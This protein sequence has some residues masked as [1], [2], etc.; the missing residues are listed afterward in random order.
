MRRRIALVKDPHRRRNPVS[1]R[2]IEVIDDRQ[3]GE[4]ILDEALKMIKSQEGS[5]L[6]INSWIDLL[7]GESCYAIPW[8]S[9]RITFRYSRPTGRFRNPLTPF[10]L[11]SVS[12]H[13]FIFLFLSAPSCRRSFPFTFTPL[14][15]LLQSSFAVILMSCFLSRGD[16]E[17]HENRIP[18]QT[19]P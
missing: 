13:I 15:C 8:T 18:A 10:P 14:C 16:M 7:S 9:S 6:G 2:L 12:F 19:S 1:D 4:T 3:T 5:K 11:P 17:R